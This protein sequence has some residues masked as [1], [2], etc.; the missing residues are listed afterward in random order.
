MSAACG[1][2]AHRTIGQGG[3]ATQAAAVAEGCTH[4]EQGQRTRN[5]GGEVADRGDGR[6]EEVVSS[7]NPE[8]EGIAGQDVE[9]TEASALEAV[10][11][12]FSEVAI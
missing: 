4:P 1:S 7:E 11:G 5:G 10:I 6:A 3:A 12:K 2:G 9:L 8:T